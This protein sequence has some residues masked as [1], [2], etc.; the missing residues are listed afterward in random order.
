MALNWLDTA[1]SVGADAVDWNEKK[2]QEQLEIRFKELQDNKQLY[3][4]LATTRYSKDLEKYY[5]ETEK[6]DN[7]KDVYKQIQSA[8]GGKG[9]D[10]H[11]AAKKIIFS[12]P[13]QF[14][15]WNSYGTGKGS[16]AAREAMV[17]RVKSGFQDRTIDGEVAGYE[18]SHAGLELTSPKQEEYFQ[19]SDYWG[20]LADEIKS[21]T[22]GPL[23]N[24]ILKLL[25]KKPAE[26]NLEQLSQKA[27]TT[28][29]QDIDNKLYTS[30]NMDDGFSL[31]SSSSSGI[32][33]TE[34]DVEGINNEVFK[35]ATSDYKTWTNK[36]NSDAEMYSVLASMGD[37][38][39]K[40]NLVADAW[41]NEEIKFKAGGEALAQQVKSLWK[42]IVQFTYE[43]T[44]YTDGIFGGEGKELVNNFSYQSNINMFREEFERRNVVIANDPDTP[45]FPFDELIEALPWTEDTDLKFSY[46]IDSDLLPYYVEGV[47]DGK[48]QLIK[49]SVDV[50]GLTSYL[51]EQIKETKA[52]VDGEEELKEIKGL[53][54][55]IRVH[56]K[57]YYE[58]V[59]PKK[60]IE[61]S[62]PVEILITEEMIQA[63]M[64]DLDKT[65]EEVIAD[66]Q[67]NPIKPNTKGEKRKFIFDE[68]FDFDGGATL[69][70]IQEQED[71]LN[72]SRKMPFNPT[73][74]LSF[75][76][77]NNM[78]PEE[79]YNEYVL[80]KTT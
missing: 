17:A 67:E 30:S 73:E 45:F 3:R 2:Q 69:E 58:E 14:A 76:E 52:G 1:L 27:G 10:K 31:I 79:V 68:D 29:K 12:D 6:Y 48:P 46:F 57:K 42:D 49:P 60:R 80:K 74:D 20:N 15:E 70:D 78:T 5:K 41:S 72:K 77:W 37:E 39:I 36:A 23:Q 51:V 62:G 47:V 13:E 54:K 56:T 11:L 33:K 75:E 9:M 22:K 16:F 59:A 26:V 21:G 43:N 44:F 4:A 7:L 64:K 34:F 28:I 50:E 25:G 19:D 61:E 66:F 65:R 55:F 38:W 18:F 63:Q 35:T 53:E 71:Q 8:N 32:I 40:N 24:Q